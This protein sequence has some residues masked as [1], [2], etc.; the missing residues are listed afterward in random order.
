MLEQKT[1]HD[2]LAYTFICFRHKGLQDKDAHQ[3]KPESNPTGHDDRYRSSD[4][5]ISLQI[6]T[7][8]NGI[9]RIV[10]SGRS[11]VQTEVGDVFRSK[12]RNSDR[13][14]AFRS[15][16]HGEFTFFDA[17]DG[18]EDG[19][20]E[21]EDECVDRWVRFARREKE[22]RRRDKRE[23]EEREGVGCEKVKVEMNGRG[24]LSISCG[25]KGG[26]GAHVL[27]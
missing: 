6:I 5:Y 4:L 27:T 23:R 7:R 22:D 10:P 2:L 17:P 12:S 8:L 19:R 20:V 9:Y 14:G 1:H 18:Y 15:P 13:L 25:Y 16:S 26:R 11:F 24:L 21:G 3:Y